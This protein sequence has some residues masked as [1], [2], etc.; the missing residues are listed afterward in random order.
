M[1]GHLNRTDFAA[2]GYAV[3]D[4][5]TPVDKCGSL[6]EMIARY[7]TENTVPVIRRESGDR[8]LHYFVIDGIGIRS[9]LPAITD[10]F[11][12][13]QKTVAQ[14]IDETLVPLPDEQVA[15]NINITG[16]GGSYRWHYDRN[17]VTAILYLNSSEGG[18]TECFPNY[19]FPMG[20]TDSALQRRLD[21][22]ISSSLV[23]NVFGRRLLVKPKPGR[24]L[25][26]RGDRCLHS[27]RPV[28]GKGERV[29]VIMSF[30]TPGRAFDIADQLN[31]YLY[32]DSAGSGGDPNYRPP[33][34][35]QDQKSGDD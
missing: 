12:D 18:E 13:V 4:D 34:G 31:K 2:G 21:C 8:P 35:Q 19:R 9:H 22:F 5:Y 7:R 33:H 32:N 16:P 24:L 27:V 14:K 26:M 23:R 25:I 15:C 29:N 3:L 11:A 20:R 1:K 30:D 6:L 17:A 10:L 28:T